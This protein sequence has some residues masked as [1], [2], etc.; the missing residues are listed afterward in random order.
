MSRIIESQ[1]MSRPVTR[2]NIPVTQFINSWMGKTGMSGSWSRDPGLV[3]D[4][5]TKIDK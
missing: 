3:S 4:D 5:F 1:I 2:L